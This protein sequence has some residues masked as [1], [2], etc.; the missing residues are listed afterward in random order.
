VKAE[1][2]ID[3]PFE[4][5]R[6]AYI[7]ETEMKS[8]KLEAP[9]H[10][11][12]DNERKEENKFETI[13]KKLETN[14]RKEGNNFET[15]NKKLEAPIY[16]NHD[17]ERKEE[18]N[19]ET[20]KE[21]SCV[22]LKFIST[23]KSDEID[24]THLA[25]EYCLKNN[26]KIENDEELI[27][28]Y[29]ID[30]IKLTHLYDN[31]ILIILKLCHSPLY[32]FA[33]SGSFSTSS[34]PSKDLELLL[35]KT[36]SC[37]IMSP[38]YCDH[39]VFIN[40]IQDLLKEINEIYLVTLDND[41][42]NV[43]MDCWTIVNS[44]LPPKRWRIEIGNVALISLKML[45]NILYVGGF[46]VEVLEGTKRFSRRY[47]N[48]LKFDQV[49]KD[50]VILIMMKLFA[51]LF[52]FCNRFPLSLTKAFF[53][54]PIISRSN[55]YFFLTSDQPSIQLLNISP[56]TSP[57]LHSPS[58]SD[59]DKT[60]I[61]QVF[62]DSTS[63][64]L[65][66]PSFSVSKEKLTTSQQQ[67]S[68]TP[69]IEPTIN[70]PKKTLQPNEE[71]YNRALM[72]LIYNSCCLC[73]LSLIQNRT[74]E[75][76]SLS[77][78]MVYKKPTSFFI[79]LSDILMELCGFRC[80]GNN[81]KELFEKALS[82]TNSLF[83]KSFFSSSS[84]SQLFFVLIGSV[85]RIWKITTHIIKKNVKN[86]NDFCNLL[87]EYVNMHLSYN[88][89]CNNNKKKI[90][91]NY[92]DVDNGNNFPEIEINPGPICV[93]H[94]YN[95]F[96]HLVSSLKRMVQTT[97]CISI[98][99]LLN[100]FDTLLFFLYS[101]DEIGLIIKKEENDFES[102]AEKLGNI[103]VNELKLIQILLGVI[104][105][106]NDLKKV[107]I[108]LSSS[109]SQ[110]MDSQTTKM[111]QQKTQKQIEKKEELE[112][113]VGPVLWILC[114]LISLGVGKT[115]KKNKERVE[116]GNYQK[117]YSY[118]INVGKVIIENNG[119][120][121]I[122]NFFVDN[123]ISMH[124]KKSNLYYFSNVACVCAC[125]L[126]FLFKQKKDSENDH[127]I[128]KY[129]VIILEEYMKIKNLALSSLSSSSSSSSF[130]LNH[131]L[132][133]I[134]NSFFEDYCLL[135]EENITDSTNVLIDESISSLNGALSSGKTT[136]INESLL[137]MLSLFDS[138]DNQLESSCLSND[139]N[140]TIRK[141]LIESL[142]ISQLIAH[143]DL[144]TS[145]LLEPKISDELINDFQLIKN[146]F[147]LIRLC[148][149]GLS[150]TQNFIDC[151][152]SF[153]IS[154]I[155]IAINTIRNDGQQEKVKSK[156]KDGKKKKSKNEENEVKK[157]EGVKENIGLK[158]III[159][160]GLINEVLL[161]THTLIIELIN[162]NGGIED[163]QGYKQ[164]V[165]DSGIVEPLHQLRDD[166]SNLNSDNNNKLLE[167][168]D[169]CVGLLEGLI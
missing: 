41:K 142:L 34:F 111:Q 4:D 122:L 158:T 156:T 151:G 102:E 35:L 45:V 25:L 113:L 117:R 58:I 14:E 77:L 80:T 10:D 136:A 119:L 161:L 103:L 114:K 51:F 36:I 24:G 23:T 140:N 88:P 139:N 33:N 97:P 128:E 91:N 81:I 19:F 100:I 28:P 141:K 99:A 93:L 78:K 82:N 67:P 146:I 48:Q 3:K 69:V 40:G 37:F 64:K 2:D 98:P 109:S 11:N 42:N 107:D 127:E 46:E 57:S 13:N 131:F 71:L 50:E 123:Y 121:I 148:T 66:P 75:V 162:S 61:F 95:V 106:Y 74:A 124:A 90:D 52:T 129:S 29:D 31:D 163:D 70:L 138:S 150:N 5:L 49:V 164:M 133:R 27:N 83:N 54:V 87:K 166:V 125:I 15:L 89:L 26:K 126:R 76:N 85:I 39:Y 167:L 112:T 44:D 63:E 132:F 135:L 137:K 118:S 43:K 143:V 65:S 153:T 17:N 12:Q 86:I 30:S 22:L 47:V 20:I 144:F 155:L 115:I 168:I 1:I 7:I 130:S 73:I 68:L 55:L 105:E 59:E 110:Q 6:F 147:S 72:A 56:S 134:I 21:L 18:N 169:D 120:F 108:G 53:F 60:S 160:M 79:Y 38:F 152:V 149:V 157:K 159:N 16:N 154:S 145:Q 165:L 62:N 94:D 104:S 96:H 116:E 84:I 8:K 101:V 9:I 32:T 92:N